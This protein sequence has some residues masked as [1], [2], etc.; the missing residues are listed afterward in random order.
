MERVTTLAGNKIVLPSGGRVGDRD[1]WKPLGDMKQGR[2]LYE[3]VVLRHG[4][5]LGTG[6]PEPVGNDDGDQWPWARESG[7]GTP[8]FA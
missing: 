8:A 5:A 2:D 7:R 3:L 6:R 4:R 1:V